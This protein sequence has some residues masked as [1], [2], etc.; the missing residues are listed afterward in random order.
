MSAR[1]RLAVVDDHTLFRDALAQLLNAQTDIDVVGTAADGDA[2]SRMVRECGPDVLLLDVDLPGP[3]PI[4]TVR[5]LRAA[6]PRM[7]ILMLS[8]YDNPTTIRSLLAL[9]VRGYL[10]KS[11]SNDEL[12]A[13]IRKVTVDSRHLVLS[14]TAR[15]F[16]AGEITQK[17]ALSDR[18]TQ[19]LSLAATALSNAQIAHRLTLAESTV[20]RHLHNTFVKLDAVSRIDAVNKATAAGIIHSQSTDSSGR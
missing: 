2:T 4:A 5:S 8:M 1:I 16:E 19:V 15:L 6:H 18:E 11:C 14:V 13:A 10:L 12:L 3:G 20:K 7:S 17:C 9:G